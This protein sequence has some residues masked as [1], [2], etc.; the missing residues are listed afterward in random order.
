MDVI[1]L[2]ALNYDRLYRVERIAAPGEEIG[3]ID[4]VESSGGSA[5]NTIVG[6]SRLGLACGFIGGVGE[7]VEGEKILS[8]LRRDHVDITQIKRVP[9]KRSGTVIGFIDRRGERT[10]YVDAGA[11]DDLTIEDIDIE[12]LRRARLIHTSSFVDKSQL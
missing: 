9:S 3:I 12:Y 5:A 4:L 8:D 1:G 10:L 6:L 2:G 7:D 11:N